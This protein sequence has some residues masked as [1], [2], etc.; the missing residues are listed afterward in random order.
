MQ[1]GYYGYHSVAQGLAVGTQ[2]LEVIQVVAEHVTK[3]QRA[4]TLL[5]DDV[6]VKPVLVQNTYTHTRT[7]PQSCDYPSTEKQPPTQQ[8]TNI[9][10]IIVN[11]HLHVSKM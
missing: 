3:A 8:M 7:R 5:H 10:I 6:V 2:V 4:A 1:V 9:G 11:L